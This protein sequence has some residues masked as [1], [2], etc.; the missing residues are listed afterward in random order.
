M[1]AFIPDSGFVGTAF[2]NAISNLLV[3]SGTDAELSIELEGGCKLLT[4]EAPE[5]G[6]GVVGSFDFQETSWG[7]RFPLGNLQYGQRRDVVLRITVPD[8]QSIEGKVAAS[9]RFS[10]LGEAQPRTVSAAVRACDAGGAMEMVAQWNRLTAIDAICRAIVLINNE[11]FDDAQKLVT[12]CCER[13][14][15]AAKNARAA[16]STGSGAVS[17]GNF[18]DRVEALL[19]DMQGAVIIHCTVLIH[20][21]HAVLYCIHTVLY[22]YCTVLILCTHTLYL[23]RPSTAGLLQARVVQ[24][25][26]P[27]LPP[28]ARARP[29]APDVQ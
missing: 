7:V 25:V 2:V 6:V 27:A 26:G 15:D 8:G 5:G 18:A 3:T 20:C 17:V 29:P 13:L 22:S 16:I 4:I 1:Y 9:L 12:L 19:Q 21:T 23:S 10:A 24:E 14:G 11:R 28:L